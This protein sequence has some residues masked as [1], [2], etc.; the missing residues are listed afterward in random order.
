[1]SSRIVR[2]AVFLDEAR[3]EPSE[4]PRLLADL[5]GDTFS[6]AYERGRRDGLLEGR[7]ASDASVAA[8]GERIAAAFEVSID[9]LR[10]LQQERTAVLLSEAIAI[11]EFIVG[12]DLGA[13]A[14]SLV[15]RIEEAL[16]FIDDAPLTVAVSPTDLESVAR[17]LEGRS[18]LEVTADTDLGPGEARV[19]G[20]WVEADITLRAAVDAVREALA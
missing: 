6:E 7:V 18:R 12:R 20:P 17:A 1:L 11:A 13:T 15:P 14:E 2:N 19:T 10:R 4:S 3:Y 5:G 16:G 8:L 9:E